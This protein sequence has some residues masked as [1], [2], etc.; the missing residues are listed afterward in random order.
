[1]AD[2]EDREVYSAF[3][4]YLKRGDL[5]LISGFTKERINKALNHAERSDF[6]SAWYQEMKS[7]VF[8]IERDESLERQRKQAEERRKSEAGA[9][10]RERWRNHLEGGLVG[11]AVGVIAGVIG[12]LIL[13]YA[14]YKLG[15]TG[16]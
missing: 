2:E 16:S 3:E 14:I 8:V 5:S 7:R 9:R 4:Q 6:T 10:T 15:W 1:M 11:L 13:A 12:G